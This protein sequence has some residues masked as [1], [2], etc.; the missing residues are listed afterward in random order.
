LND[1][2]T[3]LV[4]VRTDK[5]NDELQA[6]TY[7]LPRQL[8]TVLIL[9]DGKSNLAQ[10]RAKAMGLSELEGSLE[11]LAMNGF[12]KP[13]SRTWDRRVGASAGRRTHYNGE[14]RRRM[15]GD[16]AFTPIRARLVDLAI[17]TFGSAADNFVRKFRDAPPSWKGFEAAI[18]ESRLLVAAV[19]D[20]RRAEEFESKCWSVLTKA[21]RTSAERV[22]S[23]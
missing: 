20:E 23:S 6:R 12:V 8:R 22:P 13:N 3:Q 2:N 15:H 21:L 5:G 14:E 10:L 4:F 9:V 11:D 19:L 1:V 16:S 7:H 18:S 17:L